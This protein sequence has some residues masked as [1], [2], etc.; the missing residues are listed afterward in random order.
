MDE[1][2]PLDIAAAR[3]GDRWSIL[4]IDALFDGPQRFTDL[5]ARVARIAPNILTRRL[6]HLESEGVVLA[7]QYSDRPPRH[8]YELTGRGRDLAGALR[9]LA[10]WAGDEDQAVRHAA[11]GSAVEARWYCATCARVLDEAE[12]HDLHWI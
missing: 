10:H 11:C 3:V 1:R 7:R 4:L 8:A 9:L 6:V 5:Q 2:T 12:V